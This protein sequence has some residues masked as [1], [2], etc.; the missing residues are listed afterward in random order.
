MSET[1]EF[2][3]CDDDVEK[4]KQESDKRQIELDIAAINVDVS[5]PDGPGS[6]KQSARK[7]MQ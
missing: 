7:S 2:V 5:G 3:S 1:D 6:T 4:L